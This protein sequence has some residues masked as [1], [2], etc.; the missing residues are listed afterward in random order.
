MPSLRKNKPLNLFVSLESLALKKLQ[1]V[2]SSTVIKKLANKPCKNLVYNPKLCNKALI[3][4][5]TRPKRNIYSARIRGKKAT[6]RASPSV[7]G[8]KDIT[9][10]LSSYKQP[11]RY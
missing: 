3:H 2:K 10:H 1:I 7:R 4:L 11:N 5:H 9:F 6:L 8:F